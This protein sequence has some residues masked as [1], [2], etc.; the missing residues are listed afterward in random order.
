MILSYHPMIVADRNRI[1]AG[2]DPDHEDRLHISLAQAVILPQGC[3]KSLYDMAI[4][5]CANVFPNYDAR[6]QYN[7]KIGQIELFREMDLN[8]PPTETFIDLAD[9]YRHYP[10]LPERWM[11]DFPLVVKF[12]WGGEGETVH[13]VQDRQGLKTVLETARKYELSG[14]RGFLIQP[15]IPHRKRVL[16]VVVMD[17]RFETYWRIQDDPQ[18]PLANIRQG[19]RIDADGDPALQNKAVRAA[20]G[21]CQT[22]GINLAGLD[23][24]FEAGKEEDGPCFLEI[25]YFFGR[26]GLGGS[27]SY[28]SM[29]NQAVGAWLK[30]RNLSGVHL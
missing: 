14:Q 8:H 29:L 3:R 17:R 5:N 23:M 25:N 30:R 4:Q 13:F 6:F 24:I 22:A 2:Q 18:K 11:T 9:F 20:A 26:R 1:C 21:F 15:Y 10:N 12:D 27:E 7:G 19:G 28:Y 16:R